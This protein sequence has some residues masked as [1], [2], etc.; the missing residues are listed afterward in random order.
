MTA[1]EEILSSLLAD[2]ASMITRESLRPLRAPEP[3]EQLQGSGLRHF[4]R[5]R[6][7]LLAVVAAAVSLLLVVVLVELARSLI[8]AAPPFANKGTATSPPPYYVGIDPNDNIIVQSTATGLRTDI[9]MAPGGIHANSNADAAIAVS[10]DG[11]T[12]VAAY[13]DWDNLRTILFRFSVTSDGTVADFSMIGTGRLVGLTEL[14]LAVSPGGSQLALAGVPDRSRSV[15]PSSGPPLLLVVNLTTGR[16]RAWGGLAGTGRA[17]LIGDPV[18][19]TARNLH[20]L[21]V[22]CDSRAWPYNATCEGSRPPSGT[23]WTV[24][25][26]P[27][28]AQLGSGR[29]LVRLPGTT[30]QAQS[31]VGA[32]S[33]TTLQ[34]LRRGGIRIA[35]YAVPTGRLLR[36][37]YRGRGD[38]RSNNFYA[39]LTADGSG[40]YLLI[41][42][43]LS[44]FFGWISDGQFHRLPIH[45]LYGDNEVVAATW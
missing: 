10:A 28:S 31:G 9:V 45:G 13:N 14:S 40:K 17:D 12:Y 35:R 5:Q 26:P 21:V 39:G 30:V 8:S 29:A 22:T 42:E 44:T 19:L 24:H 11:R 36:I 34:W 1:T 6:S 41:N 2:E 33:V 27:G 16:P 38:W 4:M 20:F 25:V 18:W 15:Q 7:R 37:L 32:G 23:V 43:D 3:G